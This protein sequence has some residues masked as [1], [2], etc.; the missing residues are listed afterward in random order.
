MKEWF[1][2]IVLMFQ[3]VTIPEAEFIAKSGA[4]WDEWGEWGVERI[5]LRGE[6]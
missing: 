3:C 4:S 6:L 1:I 2:A 5:E